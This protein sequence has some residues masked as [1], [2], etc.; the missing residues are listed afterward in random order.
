M[1]GSAILIKV[2]C[3]QEQRLHIFTAWLMQASEP[4]GSPAAL[5]HICLQ[6]SVVC[7]VRG[8]LSPLPSSW[9]PQSQ[10]SSIAISA[11]H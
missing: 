7:K 11:L 4:H 5:G 3:V 8:D 9:P 1:L 2:I 10:G 6:T